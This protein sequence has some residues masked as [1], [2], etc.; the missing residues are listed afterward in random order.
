MWNDISGCFTNFGSKYFDE[1]DEKKAEVKTWMDKI[2]VMAF[3]TNSSK[4][5]GAFSLFDDHKMVLWDEISKNCNF[6]AKSTFSVK[7][8]KDILNFLDTWGNEEVEIQGGNNIPMTI[9]ADDDRGIFIEFLIAPIRVNQRSN[10]KEEVK[11]DK[12]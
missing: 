3:R 2:C 4:M 12:N 10:E 8:L 9:R 5:Q 1:K 11:N 7:Y 6:T